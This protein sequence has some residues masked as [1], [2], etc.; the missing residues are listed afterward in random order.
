MNEN[1]TI[2]DKDVLDAIKNVLRKSGDLSK[3]QAEVSILK[4]IIIVIKFLFFTKILL[5]F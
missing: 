5:D 1:K 3:I 4:C 2:T